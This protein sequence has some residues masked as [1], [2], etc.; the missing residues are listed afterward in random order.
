MSDEPII[1]ES[2]WEPT[3]EVFI[4]EGGNAVCEK[5]Y[6]EGID[7]RCEVYIL[8]D[9][10]CQCGNCGAVMESVPDACESCGATV[11]NVVDEGDGECE[12]DI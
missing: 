6:A 11:V 4:D 10:K 1:C 2:C 3:R 7:P 12:A 8:S 5:R 9:G